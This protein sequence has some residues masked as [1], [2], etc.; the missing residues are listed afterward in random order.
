M[1]SYTLLEASL[2][3]GIDRQIAEES[4]TSE[5]ADDAGTGGSQEE[6]VRP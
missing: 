1:T 6:A 5:E 2:G 4:E 3:T